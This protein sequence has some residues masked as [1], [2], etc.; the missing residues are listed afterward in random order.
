M[1]KT[2]RVT[3]VAS[4]MRGQAFKWIKPY[5]QQY[6]QGDA[7]HDVDAWMASFDQFKDKIKP[8]FGVSNEPTIARRNIQRIRQ[9]KSAADY[10]AEFQQLAA[11]T[12]WDDTAL[13]TMF[14]QGLKPKVKEEL[15]HTSARIDTLDD[16]I[17]TAI[18]ID[19]SLYE[20]YQ[21]LRDD[22]RA[23]VT[24]D[25]RPPRNSWQP[26]RYQPNTGRG[27]HN[28]TRSGYYGPEA[29][30]LSNINKGPERW[31]Q[32][33]RGSKHDKSK[34][35]TCYSCG[36]QGHFAR[37]CRSK[38]KVVRQLNVLT[39]GQ[40]TTDDSG[41]WSIL[42]NNMGYPYT[43]HDIKYTKTSDED[44][45]HGIVVREAYDGALTLAS[46]QGRKSRRSKHVDQLWPCDGKRSS[47]PELRQQHNAVE[48]TLRNQ[49]RAKGPQAKQFHEADSNQQRPIATVRPQPQYNLDYQRPTNRL[50]NEETFLGQRLQAPQVDPYT[51]LGLTHSSSSLSYLEEWR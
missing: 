7:T 23:R 17:N 10:A 51:L 31:N 2:K 24:N 14:R 44:T 9:D 12:G 47:E 39:S 21:E 34:T 22:P 42:T 19:V 45:S 5:L 27:V 4:Y 8:I 41:E 16:L 20:L 49:Y 40:G 33:N 37:D 26:N 36:K 32:K 43:R 48:E 29:M 38:N 25:R 46:R 13:M 6:N 15:M 28:N 30:D 50:G 3:L 35:T 18:D 11:S 1:P